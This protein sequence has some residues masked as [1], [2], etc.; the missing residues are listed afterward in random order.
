MRHEPGPAPLARRVSGPNPSGNFYEYSDAAEINPTAVSGRFRRST[1]QCRS[2]VSRR[3]RNSRSGQIRAAAF[4]MTIRGV[5]GD[6]RVRVNHT[7]RGLVRSSWRNQFLHS[8]CAVAARTVVAG[9]QQARSS[10]AVSGA[11]R[12]VRC[13]QVLAVAGSRS[14]SSGHDASQWHHDRPGHTGPG[15]ARLSQHK[16]LWA[17]VTSAPR[18]FAAR[19][20][21]SQSSH[22]ISARPGSSQQGSTRAAR[23]HSGTSNPRGDRD[24]HG[25]AARYR[26]SLGQAIPGSKL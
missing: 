6:E 7:V 8:A 24:F 9:R 22:P 25:R 10:H 20:R 2:A 19:A 17:A 5:V 18:A 23:G 13:S 21:R 16:L 3:A 4:S 12:F 14:P 11:V 26:S 1:P 15:M